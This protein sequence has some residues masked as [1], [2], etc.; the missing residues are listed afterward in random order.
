MDPLSVLGIAASIAQFID[1]TRWH[2]F[3]GQRNLPLG[4]RRIGRQPCTGKRLLLPTD[5][6]QETRRSGGASASRT[7]VGE[8]QLPVRLSWPQAL[9]NLSAQ[10]RSDCD[11]LLSVLQSMRHSW[12]T[13]KV[14]QLQV[15]RGKVALCCGLPREDGGKFPPGTSG[16]RASSPRYLRLPRRGIPEP[17]LRHLLASKGYDLR[18][19]KRG[20]RHGQGRRINAR[21][22]GLLEGKTGRVEFLHRTVRDFLCAKE[23]NDRLIAKGTAAV[24]CRSFHYQS[25]RRQDQVDR[26]FAGIGRPVGR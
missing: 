15:V 1:F 6:E 23:M 3:D 26:L 22:H 20:P 7:A 9:Q 14:A 13:F 24:R 19:R 2:C 18:V 11:E 25:V 10:C 12:C 5:A 17:R 16:R 21:S 4:D 8:V